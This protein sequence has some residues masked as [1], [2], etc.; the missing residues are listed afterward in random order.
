MNIR[1]IIIM[2]D[3]P[4]L[5]SNGKVEVKNLGVNLSNIPAFITAHPV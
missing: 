1:I 5:T 2:R 4:E 3:G